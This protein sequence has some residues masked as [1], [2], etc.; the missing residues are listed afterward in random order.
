MNT[1]LKISTYLNFAFFILC[2]LFS[3]TY[4]TQDVANSDEGVGDLASGFGYGIAII[5]LVFSAIW[6]AGNRSMKKIILREGESY[7]PASIEGINNSQYFIVPIIVL[8]SLLAFA[9]K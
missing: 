7:V 4:R 1:L 2:I 8:F 3:I 6:A 9:L 5:A